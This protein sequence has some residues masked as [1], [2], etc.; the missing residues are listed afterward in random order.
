MFDGECLAF[1][2]Q[3]KQVKGQW[4][5]D[6]SQSNVYNLNN[7]R[8]KASRH[9]GKKKKAYLK[10]K[11]EELETKCKIKNIRNVYRG[12]S[13]FKKGYQPGNNIVK[14]K[15]CDLVI[16]SYSVLYRW[17]NLFSKLLSVHGVNDVR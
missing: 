17:R 3:R 15:K 13:D 1:L 2:D 12:I 14:N 10:A 16:D 4:V 9:F 8:S 7:V 11:I 6:P 5:R